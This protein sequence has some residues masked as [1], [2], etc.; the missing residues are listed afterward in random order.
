MR[1]IQMTIFA[2]DLGGGIAIILPPIARAK[3]KQPR[4]KVVEKR[5]GKTFSMQ[6]S[7]SGLSRVDRAAA[8]RTL[9]LLEAQFKYEP[10]TD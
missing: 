3:G 8:K 1:S 10:R 4:I 6:I 9:R 2:S 5:S 7:V